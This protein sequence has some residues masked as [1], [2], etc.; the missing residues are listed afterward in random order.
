MNT[1]NHFEIPADDMERAK[2]FYSETFGWDIVS[3]PVAGMEYY[4]MR[5]GEVDDMNMPKEV[6]V[7]NGGLF[8]RQ[9]PDQTQTIFITV[10]SLDEY[11]DK[12]KKAGGS[13]L[14]DKIEVPKMGRF[15]YFKDPEGN[16]IGIWETVMR[17]S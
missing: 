14:T 10:S 1:V 8:K 12:I 3:T 11:I 15:V 6:G 9:K 4:G 2:K 7:I 17:E 13:I 5:S 16:V